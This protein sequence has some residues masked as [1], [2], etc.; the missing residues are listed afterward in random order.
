MTDP[1]LRAT[2]LGRVFDTPA[3]PVTALAD[4]DLEVSAG[5][6]LVVRGASGAGKST[7]LALLATLDRPT[8]GEVVVDGQAV[9]SLSEQRLADLRRD[10]LGVVPQSFGLIPVLS[11]AENVE[12]PLRVRRTSVA[13][14][15]ARVA[16]VLG[17][18]GL[19]EH[20]GQ[21]PDEL[22]G[23]QQQRVG[24]ARALATR[25]ALLVADEPTAQLDAVNARRVVDLLLAEAAEHGL[26]VV[27][28]THDDDLAA[29]ATRV[30]TL[31]SGRPA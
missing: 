22:S 15:D 29:R 8:S 16:E 14:R 12:V 11:A 6:V 25:P 3:G 17:L 26:A 27:V 4:V 7:L 30:L 9:G 13:R 28:A 20:A 5:E 31:A 19:A 18:V 24:I 1:V 23:G 10:R 2:G 21:R